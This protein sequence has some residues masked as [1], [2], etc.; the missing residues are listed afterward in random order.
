MLSQFRRG[1]ACPDGVS[2]RP[3]RK[4]CISPDGNVVA[5]DDLK[6]SWTACI[7]LST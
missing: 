6:A 1:F 7:A 3:N 5:F 2:I 4:I